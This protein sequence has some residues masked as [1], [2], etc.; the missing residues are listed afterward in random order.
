MDLDSDEENVIEEDFYSFLNVSKDATKEEINGAYRR[1]SRMYHPDKHVDQ[2][3]KSK[4]EILFNKTKKAYEVLSDPHRR[5]IYD[6]LGMK[7]LETEGWEV[8]QRTKT[9]AEIRAEYEQLAED[10]AERRKQQ[11]TNPNGNI[12]VAI[13]A[14]DLFNPYDDELFEDEFEPDVIQRLPNIEVSSMQFTQSVDFP[15]TQ[16]DTCTL[17]GQLQ[18]QNGTGGG[19][20]NLS[21]RH[22][23]SHKSWAEVEMAAGS[24]PS[25]S[26]KGFRTLSKRFFWN[27]GTVL[28]FTPEGIRP[29]IMSTMQIDK[30]SVGYLTYQGGI[31]S[32]VSTSIVRDTEFNHYNLSIQV[33]LPHSY[34]SLNY[35]R[36]MLSQELK[37]KISIKAGTF[38]GVVEYG[39]EKKVSKHSNLSF[40]V[41]VGVPSGVKLKIRLTRANQ[42]YNFPIHLCEEVMPSPV[43][44]ATVV[45]L[46]VYV[47]VKKGFVEP[48]LKE[49]KAKKV[50]KQKQNNYNKLLEKRKEAE[51]AQELMTATY[52]R[53]REEEESKK[54]L[55]II[56]AIYGKIITDP[57]ER[58][59]NEIT[60]EVIDVTIPVQCVVKDSKLVMHENTK[61]QLAGFFDPAIGEDKML[62]VIYNYREQPHEVT[63]SDNEPLRL[64]K[65]C[66]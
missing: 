1:L 47:V 29:G 49:Q 41:T 52:T 11:R 6:S 63:V 64:P 65:N 39:A 53:I 45:P 20:V 51:A 66:N 35:T 33:G 3:L 25:L 26:F 30:H 57:N 23:Y 22:I 7:G 24:G 27:G 8:V 10:R 12:T 16:K 15:L 59:D 40:A 58:G 48:F 42:V 13:N 5:A 60:S 44:Y 50:E 4:A 56:K 17:S 32:M 43:F 34:I 21:W 37:L 28:Q 9:P 46:V 36:K 55:V 62:H 19:A 18:A 38:G 61:S 31:R 14:T 2:E 54:G